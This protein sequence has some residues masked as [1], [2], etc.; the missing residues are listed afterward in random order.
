MGLRSSWVA[1]T[2]CLD[3]TFVSRTPVGDGVCVPTDE[4]DVPTSAVTF[5]GEDGDMTVTMGY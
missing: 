2:D 1:E 5:K 4:V 3:G